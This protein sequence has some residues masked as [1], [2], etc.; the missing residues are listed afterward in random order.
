MWPTSPKSPLSS[1]CNP[2]GWPFPSASLSCP[3]TLPHPSGP[4]PRT[5]ARVALSMPPQGS[6]S[7]DT[8]WCLGCVPLTP[9]GHPVLLAWLSGSQVPDAPEGCR[10]PWLCL[11]HHFIAS[12]SPPKIHS[13]E[14]GAEPLQGPGLPAVLG[15]GW[16]HS[17]FLRFHFPCEWS[18]S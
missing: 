11:C 5:P 16:P 13:L 8:S 7:E 6:F 18:W 14:A 9:L 17:F 15:L 3:A 1:W 2:K 12:V 10:W 4:R